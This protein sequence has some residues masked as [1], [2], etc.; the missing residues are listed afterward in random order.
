VFRY[1]LTS[2][3]TSKLAN[4]VEIFV[5]LKQFFRFTFRAVTLIRIALID[6]LCFPSTTTQFHEFSTD[7]TLPS[8][9][10]ITSS[11]LTAM[12]IF[13]KSERKTAREGERGA[14]SPDSGISIEILI[15]SVKLALSRSYMRSSAHNI[16]IVKMPHRHKCPEP[17][18]SFMLNS[19][20]VENLLFE[21]T[22]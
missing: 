7:L 11:A 1:S 13:A 3:S 16:S 12:R 5:S 9:P 6:R 2:I 4:N 10:S 20:P 21:L 15:T 14:A 17:P 8:F 22:C 19:T 18:T